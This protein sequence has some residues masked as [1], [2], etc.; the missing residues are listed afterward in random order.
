MTPFADAAGAALLR[1][2]ADLATAHDI[3]PDAP[4]LERVQALARSLQLACAYY[5]SGSESAEPVAPAT[6]PEAPSPPAGLG[7]DEYR[8]IA[9]AGGD[10]VLVARILHGADVDL[11]D[12]LKVLRTV[13]DLPLDEARTIDDLA[14]EPA[15]RSPRA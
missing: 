6:P 13:F 14:R 5:E 8:R 7:L 12:R 4:A 15:P 10:A 11:I 1:A 2:V 3:P 9:A